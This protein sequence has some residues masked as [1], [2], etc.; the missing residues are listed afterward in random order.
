MHVIDFF[1][2]EFICAYNMLQFLTY[3][4]FIKMS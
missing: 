2:C 3:Y 4:V 1:V